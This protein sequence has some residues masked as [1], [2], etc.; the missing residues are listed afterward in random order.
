MLLEYLEHALHSIRFSLDITDQLTGGE[1]LLVVRGIFLEK[2]TPPP[3]PEQSCGSGSGSG[4]IRNFLV[5][6][7]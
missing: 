1:E 7:G 4:R 2:T 5:G 3:P 6:S